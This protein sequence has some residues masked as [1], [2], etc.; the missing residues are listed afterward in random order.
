MV[1]TLRWDGGLLAKY[2]EAA[3]VEIAEGL[4]TG[5]FIG[6][7]IARYLG[8]T[9]QTLDRLVGLPNLRILHTQDLPDLA[10]D[11]LDRFPE[12]EDLAFG[13]TKQPLDLAKLPTLRTLRVTWHPNLLVNADRSSLKSLHLSKFRPKTRDLTQAPRFANLVEL[14]L[15][16][17]NIKSLHGVVAYPYLR[18][19]EL[20]KLSQLEALTELNLADLCVLIADGCRKMAD[21]ENVGSCVRLE[22]LKLHDCGTIRSL[23]FVDR[24]PNLKSFRF[25]GTK[26]ADKDYAPLHRLEDVY[27]TEHRGLVA[28]V[29]DF[30]QAP[31][32]L[33]RRG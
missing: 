8:H 18:R 15:V 22:E 6:V 20:H 1:E 33:A 3:R 12:L 17:S 21:H 7:N 5:A 16:Q 11:S 28:K 10:L 13:E 25:L 4:R 19:L 29:S 26:V 30:R 31:P 9:G 32:S 23:R 14:E 2:S 27:F 24:L